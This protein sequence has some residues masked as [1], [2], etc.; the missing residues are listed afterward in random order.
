MR[1][2]YVGKLTVKKTTKNNLMQKSSRAKFDCQHKIVNLHFS[3]FFFLLII[4]LSN[5][6]LGHFF[7]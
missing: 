3:N 7:Q 1:K 6:E 2:Y 5:Q 4:R